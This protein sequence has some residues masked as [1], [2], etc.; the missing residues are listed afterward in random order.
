[1]F[2]GNANVGVLNIVAKFDTEHYSA[3]LA[4]QALMPTAYRYCLS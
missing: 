3:A 2:K 1:M 4:A